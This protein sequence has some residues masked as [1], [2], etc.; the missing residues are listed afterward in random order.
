MLL[1]MPHFEMEMANSNVVRFFA[2][3]QAGDPVGGEK[4]FNAAGHALMQYRDTE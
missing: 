4:L 1:A 3:G 2:E